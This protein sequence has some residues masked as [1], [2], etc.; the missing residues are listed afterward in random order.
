M[1]TAASPGLGTP[2]HNWISPKKAKANAKQKQLASLFPHLR[3]DELTVLSEI[4]DNK[5]IEQYKKD[6]GNPDQ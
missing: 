3:E 1:A 4:T 6:L 5:D 2:R